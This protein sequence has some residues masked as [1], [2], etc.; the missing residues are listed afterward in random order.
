MQTQGLQ[1]NTLQFRD[2]LSLI[3]M[4]LLSF[5]LMADMYIT[6]AIVP[7]LAAEYGVENSTIGFAGSAFMLIGSVIGLYF[8]YACDRFARK[9][10]LIYAVLLGEVPCLLTGI[11]YFTDSFEGF[12]L[13]RLLTGL[14]IGGIY[15]ITFSLLADYVSEKH[16]AKASAMVDIAWGL[17]ILSGPILASLALDTEFGWRMAFIWA[18]LPSFPLILLYAWLAREPKLGGKESS[19]YQ[20]KFT[21]G[22]FRSILSSR[23]NLLLF[24]QGIPGSLP[25]GLLPF[26][27]ITFFREVRAFDAAD[28]T[29]IW[30]LFGIA[31]VIGGLLWAIVGDW[32]FNKKPSYCAAMCTTVILIGMLPLLALFNIQ[33]VGLTPYF[34]LVILAGLLISVG[35]SNIRALLMNVNL[36]EHRGGVFAIYNFSDSIGK[37]LGP[38]IGGLIIAMTQDYQLMVNLAISFWILCALI[39]AGT[40]FTVNKDR[41]RVLS[42]IN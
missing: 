6:P 40:I 15:P 4:V 3:L 2:W 25:W 18:A 5:F 14:G 32:L 33:W 41:Q 39:F 26:W 31:T 29:A 34:A 21:A 9:R 30:E 36:P 27:V 35:S 10:L 24:L 7:E 16:R 42:K 12:V 37:G 22:S 20:S 28:A 1:Q 23:S 17:G 19:N 13:M 11:P 38:A 8:G